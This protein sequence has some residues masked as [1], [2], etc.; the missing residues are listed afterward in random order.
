M[1][2]QYMKSGQ[3]YYHSYYSDYCTTS[4]LYYHQ[5]RLTCLDGLRISMMA[6]LKIAILPYQIQPIPKDQIK[7]QERPECTTNSYQKK[8]VNWLYVK[9]DKL[10]A[11]IILKYFYL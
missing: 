3:N 5:N 1:E 2:R 10:D 6:T 9:L 11:T 7:N 4:L 8:S